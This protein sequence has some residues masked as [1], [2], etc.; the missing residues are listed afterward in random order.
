[1]LNPGTTLGHFRITGRLGAG[2]M[3]EV[4]RARDE[5]LDR[6]VAI[7]MLPAEVAEDPERLARF[8]R[9][10]KALAKLSHANILQIFEFGEDRGITFAVTELLEGET[11][12]GRLGQ[13]VLPWREAVET[14]AA[15]AEGLA[16]AHQAGIV[17]RDLKPENVFLTEDGRV[18]VLDFGLAKVQ[19]G[20][21][22]EQ[23]TLTSP[24]PGTLAGTVLG[25]VGYMAPEQV[26]G[27][28]ADHRSDV[29][30][31]G[32][33]LHEMLTGRS[34]FRRETAVETMTAILREEPPEVALSAVE[35]T[36]ELN[37]VLGRC[38]EKQPSQRFQSASD[39][40]FALRSLLAP[41][42]STK[43]DA[44]AGKR[45]SA[46]G[47]PSVAVLP[48][49]N[50]SADAEQ[51]YF[52]GGM[53][54]EIINALTQVSGLR[55]VARTSA[56]AFKGKQL[57]V[58]EIGGALG[59][60]TVLEGSVR[61]AGRR[62]RITAQLV[63]VADGCDVWSRR[64]DREIDDVFAIQEEIALALVGALRV[65]LRK[66]ER[67]SLLKRVTE[68]PEAYA[69]YLKGLFFA[70]AYSEDGFQRALQCF[71]EAIGLDPTC[72]AAYAGVGQ[73]YKELAHL[74]YLPSA[75]GYRKAK[76]AVERA[77]ELDV[78]LG[79]AHAALG[80]LKFLADWQFTEADA[81]LRTALALSPASVDVHA[82]YAQY[83]MLTCRFEEAIALAHRAIRLDPISPLA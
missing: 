8:E 78:T 77:L 26:R 79:E 4:Y 32:C 63:D 17:H 24:P 58:R 70:H 49:A 55:V 75:E 36:P 33:V 65:S 80:S 37:R 13:G 1:V 21:V 25:T 10:A 56:F 72:A 19:Q 29:F 76:A 48:F 69:M 64:F 12:R 46:D 35:T 20:P 23:D 43:A 14:A 66:E 50:L 74:S 71:E 81:D 60:A 7:K 61:R 62:L 2:G 53:A 16:A 5:R 30:A 6:E 82:L 51:E 45:R 27:E 59:V 9:E 52:C 41:A 68:D 44:A 42:P 34:P 38:L 3:G 40:A 54:E 18:K 11:L 73:C 31:L 22:A 83:L 15:V 57:D 28:P 47:R 67:G 39:L